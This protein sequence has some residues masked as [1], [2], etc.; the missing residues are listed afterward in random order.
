MR[1]GESIVITKTSNRIALTQFAFMF[2]FLKAIK[3]TYRF[4]LMQAHRVWGG[5]MLFL[6]STINNKAKPSW[7]FIFFILI[8][9]RVVFFPDTKTKK[10]PAQFLHTKKGKRN[11]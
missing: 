3:K 11:H 9:S 4:L 1:L 6:R 5:K 7:I 8:N 2:S 10:E